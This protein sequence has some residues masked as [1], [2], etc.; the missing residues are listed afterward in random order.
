MHSNL[1]FDKNNNTIVATAVDPNN[2]SSAYR[3]ESN[4]AHLAIHGLCNLISE[5]HGNKI[6][7]DVLLHLRNLYYRIVNTVIREDKSGY[8]NIWD[9]DCNQYC[10]LFN[11][12]T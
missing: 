5:K 4:E 12:I 7:G 6:A 11:I 1:Y 2:S 9:H 10:R 8:P 3:F